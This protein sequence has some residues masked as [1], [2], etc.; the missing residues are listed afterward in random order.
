MYQREE[1]G[2]LFLPSANKPRMHAHQRF[3][4]LFS[5][6]RG[7]LVVDSGAAEA[8]VR[9]GKSL[10]PIGVLGMRGVFAAGETVRILTPER[11]VI[12]RGTVN[13]GTSELSKICGAPTTELPERLGYTPAATEVV[14]RNS[15]V[16]IPIP[17]ET[18]A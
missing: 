17:M 5:E 18:L 7:D 10:L 15:L 12:G 16:L 8:L 4:A 14:H 2:T 6:P 1:C 13:F 3:L 9:H 11:R